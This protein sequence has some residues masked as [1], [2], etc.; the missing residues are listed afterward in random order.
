SLLLRNR[1]RKKA[2]NG[3][4]FTQAL[5]DYLGTASLDMLSYGVLMRNINPKNCL[6]LQHPIYEGNGKNSIFFDVKAINVGQLTYDVIKENGRLILYDGEILGIIPNTEFAVYT[7]KMVTINS[8]LL[9][10][11]IVDSVGTTTSSLKCTPAEFE[12]IEHD[13]AMVTINSMLLGNFIVDSV[14]TTTSSLKC[15]P[16]E[17][18][19]IEHDSAVASSITPSQNKFSVYVAN[20]SIHSCVE[21]AIT[22]ENPED[23]CRRPQLNTDGPSNNLDL[24]LG[25]SGGEVNF[26]YPPL[27]KVGTLGLERLHFTFPP[28]PMLI[29]QVLCSAAHFFMYLNHK[30]QNSILQSGVEVHLCELEEIN[31]YQ[32]IGGKIRRKMQSKHRLKPNEL[33]GYE[34]K[35]AKARASLDMVLAYGIEII[36][37][38]MDLDLFAWAFFFDCSTFE[39]RQYYEPPVVAGKTMVDPTLPSH[40]DN[41]E[42]LPVALNFRNSGQLFQLQL[43]DQQLLDVG[44]LQIF[45]LTK[46]LGGGLSSIVQAPL[47]VHINGSW[48]RFRKSRLYEGPTKQIERG[49]SNILDVITIPLV[50]CATG[51]HQPKGNLV[52]TNLYDQSS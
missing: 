6:K 19:L 15:T 41:R 2:S 25:L 32:V 48:A 52:A 16:A 13:S 43:Y 11:F 21:V 26:F 4:S 28:D 23:W 1:T 8:M 30:P 17:F 36:N 22:K 12:L 45:L 24:I 14:G 40:K 10:N 18:E 46:C 39:I 35:A 42:P 50:Q 27:S 7:S 51:E 5:L 20:E 44:F 47:L 33:L 29:C 31:G 3:Y 37:K 38:N 34:V 9:G 49:P